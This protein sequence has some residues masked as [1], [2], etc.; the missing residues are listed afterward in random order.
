MNTYTLEDQ[1]VFRKRNIFGEIQRSTEKER[2]LLTT[3]VPRGES[4]LTPKVPGQLQLFFVARQF[5][6]G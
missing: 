1:I 5:F 4:L 2:F 3:C 6:F